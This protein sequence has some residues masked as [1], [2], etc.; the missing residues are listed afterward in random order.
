MHT[1]LV[2]N[3]IYLA[4]KVLFF[5]NHPFFLS[6]TEI[7]VKENIAQISIKVF[8]D[9]FENELKFT[10]NNYIYLNTPNELSTAEKFINNYIINHFKMYVNNKPVLLTY[11]G[12]EFEGN[13][14][15][16][17]LES[18]KIKS[19]K[20]LKIENK[21]MLNT[22]ENQKNIINIFYQNQEKTM[23][24]NKTTPFEIIEF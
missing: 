9:D 23:I 8:T 1:F 22:I 12:K 4:T 24:L 20:T 3:T 11:V 13:A 2:V 21:I 15:W 5:I 19:L 10:E 17:Y 6:V 14:T 7:E 16:I 18:T